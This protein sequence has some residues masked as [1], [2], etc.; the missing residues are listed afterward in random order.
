[1]IMLGK[2]TELAGVFRHASDLLL[3]RHPALETSEAFH[4]FPFFMGAQAIVW[5]LPFTIQNGVILCGA[6]KTN[7]RLSSSLA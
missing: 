7:M 1:M 5:A 3:L 2:P 6:S 4:S